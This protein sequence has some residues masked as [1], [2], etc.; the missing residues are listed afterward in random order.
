MH[1]LIFVLTE[2]QAELLGA[3]VSPPI[4]VNVL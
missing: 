4:R 1:E 2:I 3:S